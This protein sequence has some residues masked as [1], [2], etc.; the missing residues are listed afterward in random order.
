[1]KNTIIK[2]TI[3]FCLFFIS[4]GVSIGNAATLFNPGELVNKKTT[5]ND[6]LEIVNSNSWFHNEFYVQPKKSFE[7][8]VYLKVKPI[9]MP[10]ISCFH[11]FFNSEQLLEAVIVIANPY[12]NKMFINEFNKKYNLK[13]ICTT[14][15]SR[16]KEHKFYQHKNCF[17]EYK[18]IINDY[19]QITYVT[20]G[21]Y[22]TYKNIMKDKFTPFKLTIRPRSNRLLSAL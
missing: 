5:Y 22:S 16:I 12:Y 7:K 11:L 8:K 19:I 15:N 21:L 4:A 9:K 18:N 17:V 3:I 14:Q 2:K 20:S 13:G 6:I 10:E 1:M